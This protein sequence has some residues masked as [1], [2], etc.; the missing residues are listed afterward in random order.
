MAKILAIALNTFKEAIRS[1]ILY[2]ILIF[3]LLI[4][5]SAGIISELSIAEQG[6]I[7]KNLGL[8]SINFFGI[9]IA[10]FVGIGLVYNELD[11]KTIYTIISKP[12]DRYQFIL[13]KYFGLLLTIYVNILIMTLFFFFT[14][15]LRELTNPEHMMSL[16]KQGP[17]GILSQPGFFTKAAYFVWVVV[18]SAARSV[19]TVL[20]VFHHVGTEKLLTVIAYGCLE[21]AI[22]TSFAILYST[23]STPTLSMVFTVLTFVIG[24]LNE[25][26]MRFAFRLEEKR[27]TIFASQLNHVLAKAAAHL[28]P[29]LHLFNKY[30]LA[31]YDEAIVPD[32]PAVLY[33]ILYSAAILLIATLAFRRKDFK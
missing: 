21:L 25:D 20:M 24:R 19:L 10:I 17:D 4:L 3:A 12:I 7:I 15:Y 22:I 5:G 2:I 13:G 33:C 18:L 28:T 16:L 23:F 14:L 29:N 11:K 30:S 9:L 6:R 31:V 26:I 8:V 32:W 1:R 27:V